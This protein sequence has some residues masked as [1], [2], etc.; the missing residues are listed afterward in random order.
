MRHFLFEFITGGG[1]AEQELSESLL[2]EGELMLQSLIKE[3][4]HAD[5]ELLVSRDSRLKYLDKTVEQLTVHTD[6]EEKISQSI[7]HVDVVWIIA[8][9]TENC[10]EYYV[11]LF[12]RDDRLVIGS[13]IEAIK[14]CSSKYQTNKL[15]LENSIN[16]VNTKLLSEEIS[17][18]D[19]AWIVKPDDGVGAE[20]AILILCKNKLEKFKFNNFD[21]NFIFQPYI[22]G[23]QMS[24]S[25]LVYDGDARLLA[26]NRQ[27]VDINENKISLKKIG[28]NECLNYKDEMLNLAK[29]IVTAIPGLAGYIGVD[30][31][32]NEGKLFVLEINPRFTTA[33]VGISDSINE[34]VTSIILETFLNQKL[35]NIDLTNAKPV[36]VHI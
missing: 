24:M 9:E 35:P 6:F 2:R 3:L 34:N 26:C 33:Y 4:N 18:S 16:V 21:K 5:N 11:D 28:V 19:R 1:L 10:L 27:Y 12:S 31:I 13:T 23:K 25:L 14:I 30:L 29:D 15:L 22:D 20:N 36:M 7:R 8:P 32:E 17:G